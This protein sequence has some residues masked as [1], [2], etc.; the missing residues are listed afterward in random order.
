MFTVAVAVPY[1]T[2]LRPIGRASTNLDGLHVVADLAS[3][4]FPVVVILPEG[5]SRMSIRDFL[6]F[7]T[8]AEYEAIAE[9]K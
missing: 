5:L 7:R 8:Q 1:E 6:R 9:L 4:E 2:N 3:K